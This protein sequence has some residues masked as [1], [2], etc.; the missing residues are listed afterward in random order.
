MGRPM[1]TAFQ[2]GYIWPIAR[3]L[4]PE[5]GQ[6][7]DGH[8]SF[9]V[10]YQTGEDL[11]LDMHIDDSDVTFDACLGYNFTGSALSFC[12]QM[13]TPDHRRLTYI[14]HHEMGR[15]LLFLG[16]RRHGVGDIASGQRMNLLIWSHNGPWR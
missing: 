3:R 16:Q 11:G 4:F 12:G 2:H 8:H 5:E 9:I 14:Y 6:V 1:I 7:F 10:R 13:A 15:A